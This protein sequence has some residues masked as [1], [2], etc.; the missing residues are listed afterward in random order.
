MYWS[1]TECCSVW[2]LAEQIYIVFA[3]LEE[4]LE[5]ASALSGF[6]SDLTSKASRGQQRVEV[7]VTDMEGSWQS[8]PGLLRLLH[9]I[10]EMFRIQRFSVCLRAWNM[11]AQLCHQVYEWHSTI[12]WEMAYTKHCNPE[13][14]STHQCHP[15]GI[16]GVIYIFHILGL[17][18]SSTIYFS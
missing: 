18:I 2:N 10:P 17:E 3:I 13:L 7:G 1:Q 9:H 12:Q 4:C 5:I 6:D 16:N 11:M 8:F 15:G 14:L